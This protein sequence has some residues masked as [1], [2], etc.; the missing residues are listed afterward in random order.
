MCDAL[1]ASIARE[2][3]TPT[4]AQLRANLSDR[5]DE[6]TLERILE[7]LKSEPAPQPLFFERAYFRAVSRD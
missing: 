2:L 4:E 1:C 3:G 5:F 6:A 7:L